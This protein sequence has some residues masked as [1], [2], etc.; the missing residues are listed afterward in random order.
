M[1]VLAPI[2]HARHAQHAPMRFDDP[3]V[4]A[5]AT[6]RNR[7]VLGA[8]I[9]LLC[10]LVLAV[11][12]VE[13]GVSGGIVQSSA[14]P[15]V[16]VPALRVARAD[17]V[18]RNGEILATNLE[19]ASLSVDPRQIGA[20]EALAARL[21]DILPSESEGALL[22]KLKSGKRFVYL[23]HNLSPRQRW[24]VNA[25]GE[26]A[27]VLHRTE[28]RIYPH[29]R[30]AA[31]ALGHM[32][33]DGDGLMGLE[34]SMDDV[35]TNP[36]RVLEPLQTSLDIRVQYVLTEELAMAMRTY[37][38]RAAAGVV[39]DVNTGQVLAMASLPDFDP[40]TISG[41][42]GEERRN[43]VTQEVY[44]LGSSFKTFTFAA[45][46]DEGI[47]DFSDS[48]DATKPLRVARFKIHDDHPMNDELTAPEIY[49]F[50]SNIGTAQIA[51]DLGRDRHR[52]FLARLGFMEAMSLELGEVATP[53]TPGNWG[54]I[55][56]MTIS[57]GHG[58]AVTPLHLVRAIA[59]MVNGGRLI[60]ATLQANLS[61]TPAYTE[62]LSPR[63]SRQVRQLMRMAV[64][65]GTGG[66]AAA[67]GYRVGGKTGTAEKAIGGGYD[68]TLLVSSFVGVFPM[69]DPRYVVFALLDEPLGREGQTRLRS[70]G[71]TAAPVVKN[72]ILRAAPLLGVEPRQE[73]PSMYQ[74]VASRIRD[75]KR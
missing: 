16:V 5:M 4:S 68:A 48:Y 61:A 6:A 41:S 30:L 39:M 13:L 9:F 38:A 19:S 65:K 64:M 7:L 45:A 46:L 40:N 33:R 26:P 42:P 52:D 43:R 56:T 24:A 36:S 63:A 67:R 69:D 12:T 2:Q 75:R 18:D 20:P 8:I 58:I 71:W 32:G 25:I 28:E 22:G 54:D 17:I 49:A 59:A 47:I 53:I 66:R 23:A 1:Q 14:L 29:G 72:T 74:E 11:R 73:D 31:H 50:S 10:F 57:Y 27:L 44:E 37:R 62:V 3:A 51:M 15:R 70:G 55:S 21:A 60:D 35:L 34:R